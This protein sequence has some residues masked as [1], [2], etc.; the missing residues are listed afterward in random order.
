M[1]ELLEA[2]CEQFWE[3]KTPGN[4]SQGDPLNFER[5]ISRS[6]NRLVQDILEKFPLIIPAGER[7]KNDSEIYQ[8]TLFFLVRPDLRE[9]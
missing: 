3:L 9:N 1:D 8:Y 7:E 4:E 5:C 2:K 6:L